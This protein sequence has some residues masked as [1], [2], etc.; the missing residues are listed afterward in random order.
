MYAGGGGAYLRFSNGQVSYVVY[1]AIGRGFGTA[2]G[3]AVEKAGKLVANVKCVGTST[4]EMGP[5]F[6]NKAGLPEDDEEF[7]LP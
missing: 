3:V 5:D 4:S 2:D 6:F 1:T 7:D